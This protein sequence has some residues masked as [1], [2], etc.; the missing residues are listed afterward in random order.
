MPMSELLRRVVSIAAVTMLL[1]CGH[2]VAHAQ[3][4]AGSTHAPEIH[5]KHFIYGYPTGTPVTNDLIIRDSYALSSNDATKFAD[6]VAYRLTPH[7]VLGDLPLSRNWRADQWLDETETLEPSD[8]EGANDAQH[9]YDRGHLAPLGSF[10]GSRYAGQVNILSNIA[11]RG[12][13]QQPG[14][15]LSVFPQ[16]T[17]RVQLDEQVALLH[18]LA[19][20]HHVDHGS[21][22][23]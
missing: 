14:L 20:G 22:S 7:E 2:G 18:N 23:G 12:S 9:N 17:R 21:R 13:L 15:N 8:Y 6:W 4:P 19:L 5:C 16:R 1:S 10:K 11:P 3:P